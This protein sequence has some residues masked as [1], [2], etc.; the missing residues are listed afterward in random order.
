MCVQCIHSSFRSHSCIHPSIYTHILSCIHTF[1]H[2]FTHAFIRA[3]IHTFKHSYI[4]DQITHTNRH[5]SIPI[6]LNWYQFDFN[7][8]WYQFDISYRSIIFIVTKNNYTLHITLPSH[9]YYNRREV[10]PII[11]VGYL[12]Y[13]TMHTYDIHTGLPELHRQYQQASITALG[14]SWKRH[15]CIKPLIPLTVKV[16]HHSLNERII[17]DERYLRITKTTQTGQYRI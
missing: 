9:F 13:Y 17:K 1:I 3:F 4:H 5:S 6:N 15:N 7:H 8:D 10:N 16:R 14:W 11:N 2:S 12:L